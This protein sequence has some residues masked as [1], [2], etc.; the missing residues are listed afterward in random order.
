M[1]KER[2]KVTKGEA[3]GGLFESTLNHSGHV[4]A[5]NGHVVR[6]EGRRLG[7]GRVADRTGWNQG[8][9]CKVGSWQIQ[10]SE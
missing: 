1:G 7:G 5:R 2:Q 4:R 3:S 6:C 9:A 8:Q 10:Q